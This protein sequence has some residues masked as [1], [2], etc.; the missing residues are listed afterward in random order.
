MFDRASHLRALSADPVI[1][2]RRSDSTRITWTPE[3]DAALVELTTKRV[4]II[5]IAK[6]IGVAKAVA[7]A[8]RDFLGLPSLPRGRPP[9]TKRRSAR[10]GAV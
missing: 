3:M 1:V 2:A 4:G 6:K 9:R 5:P 7:R 10:K 8:R